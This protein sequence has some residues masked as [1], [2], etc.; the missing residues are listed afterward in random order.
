VRQT[1]QAAQRLLQVK[2]AFANS[3][4]S[5]GATGMPADVL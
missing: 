2:D 5:W 1:H 4:V 3:I